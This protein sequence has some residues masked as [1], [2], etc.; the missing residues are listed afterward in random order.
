MKTLG[1]CRQTESAS[2]CQGQEAWAIMIVM[3]GKS[4]ATSSRSSG[5]NT[6]GA[7]HHR[8]ACPFLCRN[9]RSGRSRELVLGDPFL[10]RAGQTVVRKEAL[11]GWVEFEAADH[12]HPPVSTCFTQSKGR[13]WPSGV[14][15]D[16]RWTLMCDRR[17]AGRFHL[18]APLLAGARAPVTRGDD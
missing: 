17:R 10:K 3:S 6:C 7:G 18:H 11:H 5:S 13:P 2:S 15:T 1:L 9:G 14:D 4:T 16:V 8:H 12:N